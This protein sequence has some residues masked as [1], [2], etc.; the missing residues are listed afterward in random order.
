MPSNNSIRVGVAFGAD[1]RTGAKRR[2]L[3]A[4]VG[5]ANDTNVSLCAAAYSIIP[6]LRDPRVVNYNLGAR[7]ERYFSG[8]HELLLYSPE[9]HTP[10]RGPWMTEMGTTS[11]P[12]AG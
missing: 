9:L 5:C 4:T 12:I 3:L 1:R 10:S 2:R 7:L 8:I 11:C 6:R